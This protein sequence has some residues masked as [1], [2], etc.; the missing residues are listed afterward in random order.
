MIRPEMF[1]KGTIQRPEVSHTGTSHIPEMV[2]QATS[3]AS[4]RR[5]V[6]EAKQ[7]NPQRFNPPTSR[8]E[9]NHITTPE[10][11]ILTSL[12]NCNTFDLSMQHQRRK[13]RIPEMKT[14]SFYGMMKEQKSVPHT[15]VTE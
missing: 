9:L 8:I 15:L 2:N 11:L 14:R 6:E 10:P 3:L 7:E 5:D 13:L 1:D 4:L 12:N